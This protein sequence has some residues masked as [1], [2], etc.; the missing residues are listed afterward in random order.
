MS[1]QIKIIENLSANRWSEYRDLYI[2]AVESEPLAFSET[3]DEIK[4][5]TEN[6]WREELQS[7][8]DGKS[9]ILFAESSGV[10]I[11]MGA[12]SFHLLKKLSHN[13][14]ISSL[15]VDKEFR[16]QGIGKQ[17]VEKLIES[18]L[19]NKS[20]KNIFSEIIETQIASIKLHEKLGFKIVGEFRKLFE[21][22]G[23]FYTEFYL[24]KE[25]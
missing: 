15:Y 19:K 24:Q 2:K 7:V 14:F 13:A 18:I 22:G 8:T 16:G 11:G 12:G 23:K 21:I 10:I 5:K 25:V 17:I 3:V 1:K 6:E 20:I 9:I 4:K